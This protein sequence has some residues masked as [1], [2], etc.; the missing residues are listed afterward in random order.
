MPA[1]SG[2]IIWLSDIEK[3]D[4]GIIGEKAAKLGDLT[5]AGFPIPHGFVVSSHVYSQFIKQHNLTTKIKHLLSSTDHTRPEQLLETAAYIKKHILQSELPDSVIA[6]IFTS[7][8]RLSGAVHDSRICVIPSL[9]GSAENGQVVHTHGEANVVL[10]VKEAWASL[11]TPRM[12]M[13]RIENSTSHFSVTIAVIVQLDM[14]HELAG[15]VYTMDNQTQDKTKLIVHT[16]QST[17]ILSKQDLLITKKYGNRILTDKQ[18]IALA[19]LG[20]KM[21]RHMYFPQEIDW[22]INKGKIYIIQTKPLSETKEENP[23]AAPKP[24][25]RVADSESKIATKIYLDITKEQNITQLTSLPTDGVGYFHAEELIKS[26]NIHPK[27]LTQDGNGVTYVNHLVTHLEKICRAFYPRPV[28][29]RAADLRSE[30]FRAM[31]GGKTYEPYETNSILGYHGALRTIHDPQLF[32]LEL[33]AI[34]HVRNKSNLKNIWLMLPYV[35]NTRELLEL[36]KIISAAGLYR[37]PTFRLWVMVEVPA[38]ALSLESIM[39]VGIDGIAIGSDTLSSLMLGTDKYNDEVAVEHNAQ[40]SSI[41]WI[42]EYI[43]RSLQKHRIETT[44]NGQA[45]SSHT[46]LIEQLVRW[47]I[48]SVTVSPEVVEQTREIIAQIERRM[49]TK[50]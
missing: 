46:A 39:N 24:S 37:S 42:Y 32:Q 23:H 50:K 2:H 43:L 30:E 31:V 18:I 20:G 48:S 1:K 45:P 49:I 40:H 26:F 27:Q 12:I 41:L 33:A 34:Q 9:V 21:E 25:S 15:K 28:L 7:Y 47:G 38:L 4:K 35:R 5:N 36:K 11:F 17:D 6:E 22:I 3:E 8:K 29:Y 19:T 14:Q 13:Q 44:I 16:T 10:K